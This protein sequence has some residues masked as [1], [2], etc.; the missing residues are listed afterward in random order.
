MRH[1]GS[2]NTYATMFTVV[3]LV[4]IY[5]QRLFIKPVQL[6]INI[7]SNQSHGSDSLHLRM[8]TRSRLPVK[9][10]SQYQSKE[11]S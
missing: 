3:G 4:L 10:Q 1:H 5:I 9:G 8:Q 6:R 2:V 7:S 11:E